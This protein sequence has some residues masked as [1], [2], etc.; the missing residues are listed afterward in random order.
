VKVVP[1]PSG[2]KADEALGLALNPKGGRGVVSYAFYEPVKSLAKSTD[3]PAF[4]VLACVMAHEV[5]HLTGMK[6][7]P[8]GIMK[9]QFVRRDFLAA[10]Q[11]RLNFTTEDGKALRAAGVA[12]QL[13]QVAP[14]RE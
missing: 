14:P 3:Q 6:H 13:A 7:S 1:G 12:G 5:G 4:L 2:L 8:S 10:A 11:G 9:P